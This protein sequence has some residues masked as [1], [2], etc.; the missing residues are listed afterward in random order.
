MRPGPW[1]RRCAER[2]REGQV[3]ERLGTGG[4][5]RPTQIGST[6]NGVRRRDSH[7]TRSVR[8]YYSHTDRVWGLWAQDAEEDDGEAMPS[9]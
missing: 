5:L 3:L 2:K 1:Q 8:L 7:K 6:E 9:C 4:R